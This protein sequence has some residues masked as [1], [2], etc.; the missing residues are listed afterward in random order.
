MT[1][2]HNLETKFDFIAKVIE[3]S[4][5]KKLLNISRDPFTCC[6]S[7]PNMVLPNLFFASKT[8]FQLIDF[9]L[10]FRYIAN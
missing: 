7:K 4:F 10:C 9:K 1:H 3:K 5:T 6:R 8:S 2:L